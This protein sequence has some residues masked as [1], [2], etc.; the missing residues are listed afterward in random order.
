MGKINSRAKGAAGERELSNILK[1]YGFST[2][3]G[4]Q[5]CGANGDADVIGVEGLHIECKRV[6][7]LNIDKAMQQAINDSKDYEIPVVI[8]RKNRQDWKVTISL[9]DFIDIYKIYLKK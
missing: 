5:F 6:E 9:E 4:Q 8:H 7:S 2:R 3:R 1:S